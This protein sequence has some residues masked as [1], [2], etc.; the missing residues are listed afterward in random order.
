MSN[1]LK[2]TDYDFLFN[3]EDVLVYPENW[4]AHQK[5]VLKFRQRLQQRIKKIHPR[6]KFSAQY[7]N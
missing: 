5:E 6:D 2:K 3:R 1:T 4:E 7:E